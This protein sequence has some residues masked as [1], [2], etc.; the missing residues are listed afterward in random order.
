MC[1]SCFF[2]NDQNIIIYYCF[3]ESTSE[4]YSKISCSLRILMIFFLIPNT[5]PNMRPKARAI[6]T[7]RIAGP[8]TINPIILLLNTENKIYITRMTPPRRSTR[9]ITF[10]SSS[11]QYI[12]KIRWV[13]SPSQKP[14]IIATS[15]ICHGA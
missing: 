15:M 3:F 8:V 2:V 1:L 5:L 4:N 12:R 14:T 13:S 11:C 7:A 6:V 10:C 9:E